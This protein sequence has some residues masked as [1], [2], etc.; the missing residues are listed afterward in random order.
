MVITPLDFFQV[1]K[2]VMG[3]DSVEFCQ[4]FFGIT[5]EAFD[6]INV[7][8]SSRIASVIMTN[9][10]VFAEPF[11]RL[12]GTK[13]IGVVDAT[14]FGVG[15]HF[16]HQSR[17]GDI[18]DRHDSHQPS[19]LQ[20]AKDDLFISRATPTTS[21]T[22]PSKVALIQFNLS[23]KLALCFT[24]YLRDFQ[25]QLHKK[26]LGRIAMHLRILRRAQSRQADRKGLDQPSML[27]IPKFTP[28]GLFQSSR[29]ISS[30]LS[31]QSRVQSP[32]RIK[33][34]PTPKKKTWL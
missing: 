2:E 10:I 9:L 26:L 29:V 16:L 23:R 21:R 17:R 31:R 22:L 14:L 15:R 13:L 25:A 7:I 5:P 20:N 34:K 18:F 28:F 30:S 33:N 24:R 1:K 11:Q 6:A 3:S 12:V 27:P 8:L 32:Y 19:A 4:P